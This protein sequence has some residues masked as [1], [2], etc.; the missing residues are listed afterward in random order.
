MAEGSRGAAASVEVDSKGV[1]DC[2]VAAFALRS[3]AKA[4]SGA[5]APAWV[6]SA[7]AGSAVALA[8]VVLAAGLVTAVSGA[9]REKGDLVARGRDFP[10]TFTHRETGAVSRSAAARNSVETAR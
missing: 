4:A 8:K 2:Q 1:A 6:I 9:G 7:E 5:T 3:P 10:T